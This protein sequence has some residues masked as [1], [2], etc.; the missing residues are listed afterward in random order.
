[1]MVNLVKLCVGIDTVDELMRVQASRREQ[2]VKRGGE[3]LNIHITRN[4][5]KRAAEIIQN[6]SLFWVMRRQI[7]ARQLIL[8][9]EEVNDAE[10]RKRCGLILD[11]SIIRTEPKPCRPFQGWRYMELADSPPDLSLTAQSRVEMP[12]EMQEELRALGLL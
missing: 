11:S 12:I 3:R 1:M 6:G 2:Q 5:P 10:G 9:I 8:R 4:R 7:R